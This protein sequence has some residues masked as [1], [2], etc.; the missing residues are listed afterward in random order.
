MK[1]S[2]ILIARQTRKAVCVLD[3]TPGTLADDLGCL[4]ALAS[5][6]AVAYILL[7]L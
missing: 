1:T 6:S 2:L 4:A 3:T 7:V 5:L